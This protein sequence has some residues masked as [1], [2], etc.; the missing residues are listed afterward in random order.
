VGDSGVDKSDPHEIGVEG[1]TGICPV[2]GEVVDSVQDADHV[3]LVEGSRY[4]VSDLVCKRLVEEHPAAVLGPR[5]LLRCCR[6]CSS[7]SALSR[8]WREAAQRR[9]L[10]LTLVTGEFEECPQLLVE[11]KPDP[12]TLGITDL[13]ELL[14]SLF[15][16]YPGPLA[17]C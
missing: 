13:D 7:C 10:R 16:D 4:A 5:I 15:A 3:A 2:C 11:G 6:N 14:D 9:P 17:C 12:F 8:L 1:R